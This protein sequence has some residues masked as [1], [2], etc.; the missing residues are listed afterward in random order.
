MMWSIFIGTAGL[1][2]PI[3]IPPLREAFVGTTPVVPPT[4]GQARCSPQTTRLPVSTSSSDH[5]SNV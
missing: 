1:L 4:P 5:L 3:T 2:L